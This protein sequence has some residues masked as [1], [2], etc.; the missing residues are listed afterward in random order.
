M[1]EDSVGVEGRLWGEGRDGG[2]E[3]LDAR[4]GAFQGGGEALVGG[5][6]RLSG[7]EDVVL[8]MGLASLTLYSS[9]EHE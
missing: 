3:S 4:G 1:G 2:V 9:N 8:D 7:G 5:W 6:V